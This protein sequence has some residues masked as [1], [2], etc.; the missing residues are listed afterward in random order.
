MLTR[1]NL[2]VAAGVLAGAAALGASFGAAR[3][4]ETAA[5]HRSHALPADEGWFEHVRPRS[6]EAVIAGRK[7][8]LKNCAHCH[9]ADATG[10]EG[11]DLHIIE[12]SDRYIA[13]TIARGIPHE[14]PAF[15]RKLS[16]TD[17]ESLVTYLRSLED[18]AP[19]FS[20]TTG[21]P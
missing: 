1:A 7:V 20:S 12:A 6:T 21:G 2:A 18:A 3:V 17:R 19:V 5:H 10:D 14:M 11:P 16:S 13:A 4:L 15:G 9:G 8:F